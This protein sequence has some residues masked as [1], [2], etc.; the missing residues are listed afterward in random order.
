MRGSSNCDTSAEALNSPPSI[1]ASSL[2]TACSFS[3]L[4]RTLPLMGIAI[5]LAGSAG[6]WISS[7]PVSWD[8]DTFLRGRLAWTGDALASRTTR[9][10]SLSSPSSARRSTLSLSAV[11]DMPD[12]ATRRSR[13]RLPSRLTRAVSAS[14][15]A[16]CGETCSAGADSDSSKGSAPSLPCAVS[17]SFSTCTLPSASPAFKRGASSRRST[18]L[19]GRLP[20]T[21]PWKATETPE[22]SMA[23]RW[24]S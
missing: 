15:C 13:S 4:A 23:W 19:S 6:S 18:P 8:R 10:P 7:W 12:K 5:C 2:A 21:S 22:A 16:D 17:D 24:P 3:K 11:P 9:S 14:P 1:V 20:A